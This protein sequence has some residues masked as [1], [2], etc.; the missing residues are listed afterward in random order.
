MPTT[1]DTPRCP[2]AEA[3]HPVFSLHRRDARCR[4]SGLLQDANDS[5]CYGDGYFTSCPIWIGEKRRLD[6]AKK[7]AKAPKM[8]RPDGS[9]V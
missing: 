6:E 5:P 1:P 8:I 9:W 4:L 7:A 2:A 3:E